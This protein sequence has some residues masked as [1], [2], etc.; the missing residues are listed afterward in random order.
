[1]TGAAGHAARGR[2]GAVR[3][4]GLAEQAEFTHAGSAVVAGGVEAGRSLRP[5]CAG[6]SA[7][8]RKEYP[9]QNEKRHA[10]RAGPGA[11]R[12][13]GEECEREKRKWK[14]KKH[15]RKDAS[16]A[17]SRKARSRYSAGF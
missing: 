3:E 5:A 15:G 16:E 2:E 14:W 6:G 12:A 7:Y 4:Q 1:M 17:G 11:Q 10:R 8:E 13:S 9:H